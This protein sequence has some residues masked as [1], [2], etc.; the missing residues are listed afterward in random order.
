MK[1]KKYIDADKFKERYFCFGY[2]DEISE[3][4]FDA[5]PAEDVSPIV[6]CK[7]CKHFGHMI[8]EGKYSCKNL[9]LPYCKAEDFCSYGEKKGDNEI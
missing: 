2:I 9:E 1:M 3:E 7:D 4:Q 6:R 5:F 8:A